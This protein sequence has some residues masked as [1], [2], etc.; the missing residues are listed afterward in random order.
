M[1]IDAYL[2]HTCGQTV[3]VDSRP[4]HDL[5]HYNMEARDPNVAFK[6]LDAGHDDY[7]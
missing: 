2:C 4:A 1:A 5:E 7:E 3:P 6:T